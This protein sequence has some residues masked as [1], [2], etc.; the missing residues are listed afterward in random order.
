MLISTITEFISYIHTAEGTDFAAISPFLMQAENDLQLNLFG[1]DLMSAIEALEPQ[2]VPVKEQTKMLIAFMA[3]RNAIPFS[4]LIQTPTGFAVVNNAN[5]APASKERI[6]R[7]IAWCEQVIDRATDLLI[8]L[9]Y[10]NPVL[11]TE[12]KKFTGFADVVNCFFITGADYALYV[13]VPGN[14]RQRFLQD[15]GKLIAWQENVLV[16]VISRALVNQLINEVRNNAFTTGSDNVIHYCKMI[17]ARMAEEKKDEVVKLLNA[18]TN[19]LDSNLAT[20][21]AYAQSDEYKLKS[22]TKYENTADS[23][24]YFFG[25]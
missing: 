11:L 1:P 5:Q 16:P 2:V 12:W 9:V 6:E 20:Y 10:A 3:Y 4:D 23:P 14:K 7:L 18:V 8:S 13:S 19:I 24:A 21:P 17:L 15:K 22:G 25:I